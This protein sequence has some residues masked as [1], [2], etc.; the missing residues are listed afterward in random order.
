MCE[1]VIHNEN[2]LNMGFGNIIDV[3]VIAHTSPVGCII[4]YPKEFQTLAESRLRFECVRNEIRF[5]IM[6]LTNFAAVIRTRRIEI[7][8]V[9]KNRTVC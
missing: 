4:K 9:L 7:E 6:F 3:D 8:V 1:P 2:R 5:G